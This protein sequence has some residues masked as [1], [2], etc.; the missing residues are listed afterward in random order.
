MSAMS[1]HS[2]GLG[3]AAVGVLADDGSRAFTHRMVDRRAGVPE[4]TASRYA[5][6][7]VALLELAATA[8]FV[9]DQH[10]AVKALEGDDAITDADAVTELLVRATDALLQEPERFRARVELQL[11][12]GRTPALRKHFLQARTEFVVPLARVLADV[13]YSEPQRFAELLVTTIEG[14]LYRQLISGFPPL[15]HGEIGQL[16]GAVVRSRQATERQPDGVSTGSR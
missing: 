3:T 5:R 8:M 6:T 16:L 1:R 9:D 7:R 12:A 4:G 2:E 11:E 14:I 10:D 13:G 15:H